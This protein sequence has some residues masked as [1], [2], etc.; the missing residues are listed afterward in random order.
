MLQLIDNPYYLLNSHFLTRG[1]CTK[2]EYKFIS[3]RKRGSIKE[4]EVILNTRNPA[5]I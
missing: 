3:S 1:K 2:Y 4:G 5:H